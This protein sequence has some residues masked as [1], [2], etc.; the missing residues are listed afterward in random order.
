M[1]ENT[2]LKL[3]KMKKIDL[4]GKNILVTGAT[5]GIGEVAAR[6]LALMGAQV[7]IVGRNP[8]R[9]KESTERIMDAGKNLKILPFVA[10]LSSIADIHRVAGEVKSSIPRLDVL[11]NNAGAFFMGKTLSVDGFEMTF[12]LNHLNYFLLTRELM[13]LLKSST[14]ARVVCVSSAAHYSGHLKFDDLQ[15][16]KNFSGWQSYSNSKLMNVLFTYKLSQLLSGTGIS[17]NVLHPGF[18]ATNFGKSNG[19]IFKPIFG[20][21]QIGA[22]SSD[23][24]AKTSIY[25]ASS[26]E[27]EGI[28]GKYFDK[29]KPVRSSD[30]SYDQ[31]VMD[32]LWEESEK[33]LVN[34]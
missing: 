1:T 21:A 27:V 34:A 26:T 3:E 9:V 31:S 20:I 11:L 8:Q 22:I 33:I 18:V 7:L 14:P 23:E 30:E 15:G 10:D 19:G 24:G 6:E 5:S 2:F 17:A 12:A 4:I 32:R 13:D 29:S 16:L 28:S 25:L